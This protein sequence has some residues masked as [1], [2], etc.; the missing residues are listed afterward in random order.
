M[1]LK[2]ASALGFMLDFMISLDFIGNSSVDM[3]SRPV[4]HSEFCLFDPDFQP[5]GQKVYEGVLSF[6]NA[7]GQHLPAQ[8]VS[9]KRPL[10]VH[11]RGQAA[12][13]LGRLQHR[14]LLLR[15]GGG[16]F[17]LHLEAS[18]SKISHAKAW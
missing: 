9:R 17:D 15:A 10:F 5:Q 16:A 14:L 1:P 13:G 3:A 7:H 4:G 6:V 18:I 12:P 8:F 11:L 2:W